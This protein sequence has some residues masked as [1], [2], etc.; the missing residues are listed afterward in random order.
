MCVLDRG[1]SCKCGLRLEWRDAIWFAV[2]TPSAKRSWSL[3]RNA[4]F[5]RNSGLVLFDH[6]RPRAH[7]QTCVRA[8][9]SVCSLQGHFTVPALNGLDRVGRLPALCG[10]SHGLLVDNSVLP[11]CLRR[12]TSSSSHCILCDLDKIS[13]QAS[14][15]LLQL[16]RVK[17]IIP[18]GASPATASA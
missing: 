18:V 17:K 5:G 15:R 1:R 7:R 16:Q 13:K 6:T 2:F 10:F 9:L 4:V 11:F 14:Q 12:E 8:S 3:S